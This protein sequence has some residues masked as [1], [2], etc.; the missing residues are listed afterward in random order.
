VRGSVRWQLL[1]QHEARSQELTFAAGDRAGMLGLRAVLVLVLAAFTGLLFH[2]VLVG[3]GWDGERGRSCYRRRVLNS[4]WPTAV[5][6]TLALVE[7]RE[8]V[9]AAAVTTGHRA[10]LACGRAVIVFRVAVLAGFF[11]HVVTA[12]S[13]LALV[14]PRVRISA[15]AGA[16]GDWTGRE[17]EP[18]VAVILGAILGG[19]WA[20]GLCGSGQSSA[21]AYV[22]DAYEMRACML[23][24]TRPR[25]VRVL[26][27]T[28]QNAPSWRPNR[29][30]C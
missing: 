16:A 23:Q 2:V 27:A 7:P 17:G 26:L 5:L 1:L 10:S 15:T 13:A 30:L 14:E 8:R 24:A 28:Q 20:C 9:L 12:F 6:A 3:D 4:P 18:V 29:S 11:G 25:C 21:C 22:Q 19:L